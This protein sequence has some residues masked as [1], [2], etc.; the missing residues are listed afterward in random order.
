MPE[1]FAEHIPNDETGRAHVDQIR[2]MATDRLVYIRVLW[3]GAQRRGPEAAGRVQKA[4][5][6]AA[7]YQLCRYHKAVTN[8]LHQK[9]V[10]VHSLIFKIFFFFHTLPTA[11]CRDHIL[12]MT[13][14]AVIFC[15]LENMLLRDIVYHDYSHTH[16]SINYCI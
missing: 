10:I 16:T 1:H 5:D 14:T 7:G 15:R 12:T 8:G 3:D 2:H 6:E 9:R 11:Y 13:W 4:T